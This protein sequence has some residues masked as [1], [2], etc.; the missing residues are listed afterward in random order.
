MIK[1]VKTAVV[2]SDHLFPLVDAHVLY[3]DIPV[4]A[5]IDASSYCNWTFWRGGFYL[6]FS[7]VTI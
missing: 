5:T 3:I 4:T 6:P 2:I 7:F 1:E